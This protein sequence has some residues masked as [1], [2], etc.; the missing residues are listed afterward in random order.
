MSEGERFFSVAG[1]VNPKGHYFIPH[2]LNWEQLKNFIEKKHYFIL[3][4]PRQSGKT[5]AILEW[6]RQLNGEGKYK[7]FYINIEAV[8]RIHGYI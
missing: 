1:A 7:A 8:C 4:A 2:R 6:T 3:H 5:T